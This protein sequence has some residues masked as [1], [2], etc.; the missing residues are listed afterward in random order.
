MSDNYTEN[1]NESEDEVVAAVVPPSVPPDPWRSKRKVAYAGVASNG[2]DSHRFRLETLTPPMVV[3]KPPFD[4]AGGTRSDFAS[5]LVEDALALPVEG[6]TDEARTCLRHMLKCAVK[7]RDAAVT[8]VIWMRLDEHLE[9]RGITEPDDEARDAL[10]MGHIEFTHELLEFLI[11]FVRQ[12]KLILAM[13]HD[14]VTHLKGEGDDVANW[15]PVPNS[16]NPHHQTTGMVA[17]VMDTVMSV[18][19]TICDNSGDLLEQQELH[20]RNVIGLPRNASRHWLALMHK[21]YSMLAPVQGPLTLSLDPAGDRYAHEGR[22]PAPWEQPHDS[23]SY[24]TRRYTLL[25]H[26]VRCSELSCVPLENVIRASNF[27]LLD[28]CNAFLTAIAP[29]VLRGDT[30]LGVVDLLL[31]LTTRAPES[32]GPEQAATKDAMWIGLVDRATR[33][34]RVHLTTTSDTRSVD[35]PQSRNL[36]G[37]HHPELYLQI[38]DR[39]ADIENERELKACAARALQHLLDLCVHGGRETLTY[40]V[41]GLVRLWGTRIAVAPGRM[42]RYLRIDNFISRLLVSNRE[43]FNLVVPHITTKRGDNSLVVTPECADVLGKAVSPLVAAY[44]RS[45]MQRVMALFD[46]FPP[47]VASW[48]NLHT[49]IV[50]LCKQRGQNTGLRFLGNHVLD[51]HY[52][53]IKKDFKRFLELGSF[54]AE[55]L[56]KALELASK[57]Q[58][59]AAVEVLISDPYCVKH[60]SNN[61]FVPHLLPALLAPGELEVVKEA[62]ASFAKRQKVTKEGQE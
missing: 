52:Q 19:V 25:E 42:P 12:P 27:T 22:R 6:T 36:N 61:A 60:T 35:V 38:L 11:F 9:E 10:S 26:A 17:A 57:R 3:T 40:L 43:A 33:C 20:D 32:T 41:E 18:R 55:L 5:A 1:D 30:V 56:T 16:N 46:A 7:A 21:L 45:S 28:P 47:D 31:P 23:S 29:G 49:F 62:G 15:R 50:N 53:E 24:S 13:I 44:D 4:V 58:S 39:M 59:T 54:S 14:R 8:S 34:K 51:Q 48:N 37:E 2:D